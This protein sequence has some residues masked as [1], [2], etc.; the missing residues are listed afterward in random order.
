MAVTAIGKATGC[1]RRCSSSMRRPSTSA[2]K[3]VNDPVIHYNLGLTYSEDVPA[4]VRQADLA[5]RDDRPGLRGDPGDRA[6]RCA[7]LHQEARR[8]RSV[9]QAAVQQLRREGRLP[10]ELRVQEDEAVHVDLEQLASMAA[11]HLQI[12]IKAQPSDEAL[13]AELKQVRK[14]MDSAQAK[15]KI[16]ARRDAAPDADARRRRD[17]AQQGRHGPG[18]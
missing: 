4:R 18:S 17:P 13:E 14:D 9:R 1:S 11:K 5:R 12:W 3:V 10:L 15:H 6:H 7:G 16:P 2:I 8:A